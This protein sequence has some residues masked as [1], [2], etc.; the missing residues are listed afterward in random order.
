MIVVSVTP[1]SGT[2]TPDKNNKFPVML[3]CIA[4]KMPNR[5]VLSGTVAERTGIEIGRTYLMQV[6]EVGTDKLFG[7]DF[8]FVKIRELMTGE[9]IARTAKELG[10]PE[11]ILISRP[12]GFEDHYERKGDAIESLRTKREKEGLYISAVPR[13]IDHDTAA[14]VFAGTSTKPGGPQDFK[15]LMNETQALEQ[16][17]KNK[18]QAQA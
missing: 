12:E 16:E 11:I 14:K 3:Q 9:D 4:G 13:S 17:N 7:Q 2:S 18:S 5:N 8:N 1:F 15:D 10:K 6:R